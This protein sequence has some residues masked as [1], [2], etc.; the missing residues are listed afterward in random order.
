MGGIGKTELALQYACADRKRSLEKQIYQLGICWINVADEGNVGTQILNF[1]QNYLEFTIREEGELEDKVKVCWQTWAEE[2]KKALIIFDDVREYQQIKNF[3]PPSDLKNFK[4]IITTRKQKLAKDIKLFTVELLDEKASLDLIISLIGE[5]RINN[6]LEE[7]KALCK[8]LG[9]LPLGLELVGRLLDFYEDWSI[10]ELRE[11]LEE[12]KLVIQEE[13]IDGDIREDLDEAI[14][15]MTA[16]RGVRAAFEITWQQLSQDAQTIAYYLSLFGD[17]PVNYELIKELCSWEKERHLRNILERKLVNLSLIKTVESKVYEVHTLIHQYLREKLEESELATVAKEAY[18]RLMISVSKQIPKQPI[19]NDIKGLT[20]IIPHLT[21]AVEELN[22]WINDRD[23]VWPYIGISRFYEAQGFYK[24]AEPWRR[25]CLDIAKQRLGEDHPD[26]ASSLNNLAGLY[27]D[28]GRYEKAEPLYL[29]ALEL[30]K[31]L[32]G[33]DHPD[34][35]TSLNNLA[36]L[37]NAQGRYEKA[38]PLY[39][40]AL[41]LRKKLLG[42]DH[43]YVATS[44]NN[45]ALLYNAQGRYEKAEPLYLQALELCKKLLGENHPNTRTIKQNYELMKEEMK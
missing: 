12:N 32:L 15:E 40:Q 2:D 9:Y 26:V 33:E 6:E 29:Q 20:S 14:V 36:G 13:D 7:S 38:E 44:L 11:I 22:Q 1:A 37:Y 34:V 42:E 10:S 27:N 31:K 16:Q 28:Q 4:V 18:C 39:L 41:E 45:L 5:D 43:P 23:L 30:R 21:V 25:Q 8:D 19:K 35:A 24:E 3:L 17:S